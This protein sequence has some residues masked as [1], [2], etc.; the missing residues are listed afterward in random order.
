LIYN[1]VNEIFISKIKI[2]LA[3]N[4]KKMYISHYVWCHKHSLDIP[5]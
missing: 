2:E 4:K 5:P 1:V 3:K